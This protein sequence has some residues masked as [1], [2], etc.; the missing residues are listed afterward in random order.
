MV[1]N[2]SRCCTWYLEARAHYMSR[3]GAAR[4]LSGSVSDAINTP[5]L[6]HSLQRLQVSPTSDDRT[7]AGRCTTLVRENAAYACI[8]VAYATFMYIMTSKL[9]YDTNGNWGDYHWSWALI[10]LSGFGWVTVTAVQCKLGTCRLRTEDGARRLKWSR[11]S[12]WFW[13]V[14]IMVIILSLPTVLYFFGSVQRCAVDIQLVA[15]L[16]LVSEDC[17]NECKKRNCERVSGC[18]FTD[19]Q[20][21]QD[22]GVGRSAQHAEPQAYGKILSSVFAVLAT[23][24]GLREMAG[25]WRNY[26]QPKLQKQVVRIL[27]MVPIYAICSFLTL[28]ACADRKPLSPSCYAEVD[29]LGSGSV[30]ASLAECPYTHPCAPTECGRPR[31]P[32]DRV[33]VARWRPQS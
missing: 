21:C 2:A 12:G 3:V 30:S 29:G 18:V 22:L 33:H 27:A 28:M 20:G 31:A 26:Y 13:C 19:E 1:D 10:G 6:A 5:L 8:G 4:S 9:R 7:N 25:H 16:Q 24:L 23:M 14:L 11:V 32:A 15:T 17:Q